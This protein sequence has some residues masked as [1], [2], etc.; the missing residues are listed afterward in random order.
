[1]KNKYIKTNIQH[2][3]VKNVKLNMALSVAVISLVTGH[4]F[5]ADM[6][7]IRRPGRFLNVLCK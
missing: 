2:D 5:N 1:M 4:Q 6:T 3:T 7:F